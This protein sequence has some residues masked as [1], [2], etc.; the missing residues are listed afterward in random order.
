MLTLAGARL[1]PTGNT[2]NYSV[3]PSVGPYID[4]QEQEEDYWKGHNVKTEIQHHKKA[5]CKIQK[6]YCE[7]SGF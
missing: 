7:Q 4:V 2:V 3:P 5:K 1:V 6:S